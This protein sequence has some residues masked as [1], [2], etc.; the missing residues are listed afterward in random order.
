MTLRS[1]VRSFEKQ[2]FCFGSRLT[3]KVAVRHLHI[4]TNRPAHY[5]IGAS[6]PSIYAVQLIAIC[7]STLLVWHD[8]QHVTNNVPCSN[9]ILIDNG[10]CMRRPCW[11]PLIWWSL[12]TVLHVGKKF[13]ANWN[14][15]F[16]HRRSRKKVELVY[17]VVWHTH[18]QPFARCH[19]THRYG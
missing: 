7:I 1:K 12:T 17:V 19:D 9:I 2:H 18:R 5:V 14:I 3:L 11:K 13:C 6:R 10:K 16:M 8:F 4:P 15:F